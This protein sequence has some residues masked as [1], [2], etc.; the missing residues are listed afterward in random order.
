MARLPDLEAM[1]LRLLVEDDAEELHRVVT[2]NRDHL[3]AWLPWAGEQTLDATRDFIASTREQLSADNGF[4]AAVVPD[5]AIDGI[6]GFH[7]VDWLNRSTSI[8][9]WLA[10]DAQGR[11]TMT[12]LVRGLVDHAFG[13]WRLHRV[14]IDA[15]PENRRSRA[16]PERLGFRQEAR[17]RETERVA[18]RYLDSIVYGLLAPE[19]RAETAR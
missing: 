9:Y 10:A 13:A 3:T 2:A 15:A 1:G 4:Q 19:W 5:G 7:S 8:G 14:E 12:A 16:I 17:L 11:G 18:G 6:V